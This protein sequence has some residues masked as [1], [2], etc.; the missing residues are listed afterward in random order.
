MVVVTSRL[1]S[2]LEQYRNGGMD[3][4]W[5]ETPMSSISA[6]RVRGS[7]W[8]RARGSGVFL[9]TPLTAG[10]SRTTPSSIPDRSDRPSRSSHSS[11]GRGIAWLCTSIASAWTSAA[12][13]GCP[14]LDSFVGIHS[15]TS[16]WVE[17]HVGR[18][19]SP[20]PRLLAGWNFPVEPYRRLPAT[21]NTPLEWLSG[22]QSRRTQWL[23]RRTSPRMSRRP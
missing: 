6:S 15:S 19:S 14:S 17:L 22:T 5:A 13:A 12:S 2:E 20:E 4:A 1:S 16:L 9:P 18:A 10:S 7:Y 3:T 23:R 21:C 8:E 11:N